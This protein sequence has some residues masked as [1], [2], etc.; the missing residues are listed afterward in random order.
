MKKCI[1]EFTTMAGFVLA[2]AFV[3]CGIWIFLFQGAPKVPIPQQEEVEFAVM[4]I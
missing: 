2:T 1:L 3:I 4:K